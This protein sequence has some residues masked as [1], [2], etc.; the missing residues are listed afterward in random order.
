M[1]EARLR[2]FV[3]L[4]DTGSV[5]AAARRL[6]V[7]ES[8]VSAA[9]AALTR[10]LGVPLVQRVGRG[11]RLTRPE[12]STPDTRGRS[13]ACWRRAVRRRAAGRSRTRATAPGRGHDGRRPDPARAAR[14]IPDAVARRRADAG[15]G[16][17]PPGVEQ[18]RRARGR[19][20]A[21][22]S[23]ARRGRGDRAGQASER[24]GG[25]R[26]PR[27]RGRFRPRPH[28][29]GHAR[30]GSGTR[31]TADAYLTEREV[32]PPRLVLGSNGAVIAARRPGSGSRSS[33][34]TRSA[35]N[36]TPDAS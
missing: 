5:R 16:P 27:P 26:R 22:G 25:R 30:A 18:P 6:Y 23:S 21:R 32:A 35:P 14:L 28:A 1:T 15:G 11:I 20:G 34:G 31:A 24:A 2:T 8:A 3:A 7:T 4:A 10:D 19:P 33:H 12:P 36:C 29:L 17:A 9:V 13:S